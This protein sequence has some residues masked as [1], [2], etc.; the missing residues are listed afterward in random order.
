MTWVVL[1]EVKSGDLAISGKVM[2]TAGVKAPGAGA[3]KR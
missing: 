2:T 1:E 3:A